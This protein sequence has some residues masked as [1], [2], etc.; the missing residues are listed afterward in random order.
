M[1]LAVERETVYLVGVVL[2]FIAFALLL[3]FLHFNRRTASIETAL[4]KVTFGEEQA[5][6]VAAAAGR[7]ESVQGTTGAIYAAINGVTEQDSETL[8][9]LLKRSIALSEDTL[10]KVDGLGQSLSN[11]DARFG[12]HL[13][14]HAGADAIKAA[15]GPATGEPAPSA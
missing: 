4:G 15:G 10:G 13:A 9:Q 11:L 6:Q 8:R 14:F 2:A 12:E 3:A 7:L 5:K 1:L